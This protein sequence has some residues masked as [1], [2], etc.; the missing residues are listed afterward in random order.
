MINLRT[1]FE[2]SAVNYSNSVKIAHDDFIDTVEPVDISIE[3]G[4]TI[5]S[6]YSRNE[7]SSSAAAAAAAAVVGER[8]KMDERDL[9]YEDDG[10][11]GGRDGNVKKIK[12]S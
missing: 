11:E 5:P 1:R 10:D 12:S 2:A 8:R 4:I 6:T 3:G 7:P 9:G